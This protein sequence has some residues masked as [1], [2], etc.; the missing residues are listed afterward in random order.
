M[1]VRFPALR[2]AWLS[3]FSLDRPSAEDAEGRGPNLWFGL[4][5]A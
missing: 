3:L 4:L 5:L 1:A 2:C